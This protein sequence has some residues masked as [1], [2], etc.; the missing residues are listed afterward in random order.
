MISRT[1]NGITWDVVSPS[2]W[3]LH[4]QP[5]EIAYVGDQWQL[6][7]PGPDGE[8][9]HRAFDSRS[10]AMELIETAIEGMR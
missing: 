6:W 4:G 1:V 3:Q 10:A 9:L 5:V 7:C 8:M 2:F